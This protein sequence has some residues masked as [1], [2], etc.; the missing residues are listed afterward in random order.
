MDEDTAARAR[1]ARQ[2]QSRV[3]VCVSA[4]VF[5]PIAW[6]LLRSDIRNVLSDSWNG[7]NGNL[8]A[9]LLS[10]F[11]ASVVA[12]TIAFLVGFWTSLRLQR[13]VDGARRESSADWRERVAR[14]IS[15]RGL[16]APSS[17]PAHPRP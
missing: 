17:S 13:W 11:W 16:N 3:L 9:L 2:V 12:G 1:R 15:E 5:C 8:P 7:G 10:V 14:D 6:Y 4:T